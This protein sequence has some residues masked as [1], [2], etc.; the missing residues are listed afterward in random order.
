M[1][2]SFDSN[3]EIKQG[4]LAAD[5][6]FVKR[7]ERFE[8]RKIVFRPSLSLKG[9]IYRNGP[10]LTINAFLVIKFNVGENVIIHYFVF[11]F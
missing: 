1:T 8:G 4:H 10:R 9:N 11:P 6:A 3:L 7:Y 5:V 2:I